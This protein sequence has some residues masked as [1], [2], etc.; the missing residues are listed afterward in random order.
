MMNFVNSFEAEWIKKKRSFAWWLVIIGG[1]FTPLVILIANLVYNEPLP[2]AYKDPL[3]WQSL[4]HS[5]MESMAIF[6][7]P[8]GV[9]MSTSLIT[10]MEF[11]NNTWK[12]MHT[13]PQSFTTL[14][15]AKLTVITVMM[16]QFFILFNIGVFLTAII[17]A[18]VFGDVDFPTQP[19]PW[20]FFLKE[21]AKFMIDCL[22]IIALQ[23]LLGLR[24]K[25]FLVPIGIGILIWIFSIASLNWEYSY[26]VPYSYGIR[27]FFAS[28][29][30]NSTT[31]NTQAWAIGY[32][33]FFI[34]AGYIM[35]IRKKEKG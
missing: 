5:A 31:I 32:F 35:Y 25:N 17:P 10:Q 30:P 33:V 18:L 13:V 12:Q 15:M 23:Y 9:I 27:D 19:Y 14:F 2:L 28:S 24:F 3:F 34:L 6:L 21:N 29:Q 1:F 26:L 22:P 4:W 7:L 16:M 11:R 20:I 8:M